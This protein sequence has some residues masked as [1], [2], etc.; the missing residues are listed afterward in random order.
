MPQQ[1]PNLTKL[2]PPTL[3]N[4]VATADLNSHIDLQKLA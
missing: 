2:T 1:M 4:I 3:Q